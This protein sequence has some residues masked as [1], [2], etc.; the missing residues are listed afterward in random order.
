VDISEGSNGDYGTV[1]LS[2]AELTIAG[3]ANIYAGGF[4][5]Y[6]SNL[7]VHGTLDGFGGSGNVL[8]NDSSAG[9]WG[10]AA[11]VGFTLQDGSHFYA[12]AIINSE[13][14]ILSEDSK[15]YAKSYLENDN[16][17][18]IFSGSEG[19]SCPITGKGQFQLHDRSTLEFSSS[20]DKSQMI[21][22]FD[23]SDQIILGDAEAFA[24]W[25]YNFHG[26]DTLDLTNFVPG[27]TKLAY[28]Q[29]NFDTGLLT[30]TSG[31]ETAHITLYGAFTKTDFSLT[32]DASGHG[33]LIHF[34]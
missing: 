3:S 23:N 27:S 4:N 11:N 21:A 2:Q 29:E 7:I 24:G 19:L 34:V 6:N 20:V 33:T 13:N 25:L 5:V 30:L 26:K 1:N 31:A 10:T 22:M 18:N 28:Q 17:F 8:L 16:E 12:N 14:I 9:I 15:V 32:A